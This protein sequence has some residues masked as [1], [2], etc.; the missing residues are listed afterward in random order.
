ML[1]LMTAGTKA[2]ITI[3]IQDKTID[4]LVDESDAFQ[5]LDTLLGRI[6]HSIFPFPKVPTPILPETKKMEL[7]VP[8]RS[9]LTQF[10][11]SQPNYIFSIDDIVKHFTGKNS[12]EFESTEEL[13]FMNAL[14]AKANRIRQEIEKTEKGKWIVEQKGHQ[15]VFKFIKDNGGEFRQNED[16]Q[17]TV[18]DY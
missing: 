9:I 17:Q 1:R 4:I 7:K 18:N 10:I 8:E 2:K 5:V 16:K 6:G 12:S 3:Q 13:N 11:K 14:R 15:K